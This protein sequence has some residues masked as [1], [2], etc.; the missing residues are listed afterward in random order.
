MRRF[1]FPNQDASIYQSLPNRQ[2]GLDEILEIGKNGFDSGISGAVR[3]LVQFDMNAVSASLGSIIS[4]SASFD[5]KLFLARADRLK[6]NQQVLMYPVSS[7]WVEGSGYFYQESFQA[8]DGATW[9]D[10]GPGVSGLSGSFTA[11]LWINSGSDFYADASA[12]AS[13]QTT[14][15]IADLTFDT[16]NIVRLWLSG[17]IPNNGIVIKYP[18]ADEIDASNYGALSVFARNTHTVYSPVLI[19]K[20]DDSTY[21]TGS[22]ISA[23]SD[24]LTVFPANLRPTYKQGELTRIDLVVREQYPLKTF[25]NQFVAWQNHY[26]PPTSYYSVVD[27]QSQEVVIPFDDNS[28]ISVDTNSTFIR[29]VV[30]KMY[31]RRY[32]KLMFKVMFD[33]GY[34]YI[35]DDGY[36][37]TVAV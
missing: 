13:T 33:N 2:A 11:S 22:W 27:T 21:N 7:S 35:F 5:I 23:S 10:R 20:W 32:Y 29:F 17:T 6:L 4:P 8:T 9:L 14:L 34:Q 12:S 31:P 25:S 26:L 36:T 28:K 30:E 15:P 37:F 1:F 18:D 3:A 16:T 19:A 24:A